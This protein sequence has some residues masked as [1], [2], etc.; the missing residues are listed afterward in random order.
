MVTDMSQSQHPKHIVKYNN[1]VK[2]RFQEIQTFI[3]ID[4]PLQ[5]KR[6]IRYVWTLFGHYLENGIH[7]TMTIA[8]S[9]IAHSLIVH[10]TNPRHRLLTSLTSQ[11]LTRQSLS[12][13]SPL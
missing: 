2:S 9:T 5:R 6:A 3:G 12:G 8:H 13:Q 7:D 4:N 10:Q 1:R 11:S